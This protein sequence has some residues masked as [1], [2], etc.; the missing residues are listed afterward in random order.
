M[1]LQLRKYDFLWYSKGLDLFSGDPPLILYHQINHP[2]HH[3]DLA[4]TFL[5]SRLV[6]TLLYDGFIKVV[7]FMFSILPIKSER[8][9]AKLFSYVTNNHAFL[10]VS[11]YLKISKLLKECKVLN[12]KSINNPWI[13]FKEMLQR[14]VKLML[15]VLSA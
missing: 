7:S 4:S 10:S 1:K 3:I 13:T 5:L 6:Y 12:A 9:G 11:R 15:L 8:M 2:F 14:T